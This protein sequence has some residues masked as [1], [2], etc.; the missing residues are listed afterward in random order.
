MVDPIDPIEP[1]GLG[2]KWD[3][4][5][6]RVPTPGDKL[7]LRPEDAGY[8]PGSVSEQIAYW[9]RRAISAEAR[10]TA[11]VTK[12]RNDTE[13]LVVI[14][15]P[16]R[17]SG[18]PAELMP[19]ILY[20][21]ALLRDSVLRGEAPYMSHLLFP[22]ALDDANKD[23][24]AAGITAGIAWGLRSKRV[25]VGTDRGVSSGMEIGL[26]RYR[27]AGLS[28]VSRSLGTEWKK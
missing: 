23:E 13:H 11:H 28:V 19:N 18:D 26:D 17:G 12:E 27:Q 21:R 15:S 3:P 5:K 1:A 9:Q 7:K 20:A 8:V 6:D 25:V 24:R 22:G 16:F 10:L 14:E 2:V 4:E